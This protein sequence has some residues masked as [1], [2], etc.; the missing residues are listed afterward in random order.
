MPRKTID[1]EQVK[2]HANLLLSME[3]NDQQKL[4]IITMLE[5]ILHTTD[6]YRGFQ[7]NYWKRQG[8]VEWLKA[9]GPEGSIKDQFIYGTD[10]RYA[11]T[12]Y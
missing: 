11:R 1:V 3:Y 10:G 6:N 2:K 5:H 9:G 8:Y 4:G 12:Y 7:Y